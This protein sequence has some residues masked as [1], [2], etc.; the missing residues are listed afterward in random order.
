MLGTDAPRRS[1]EPR[2]TR[3][4]THGHAHASTWPRAHPHARTRVCTP[5]DRFPG[6]TPDKAAPEAAPAGGGRPAPAARPGA[7]AHPANPPERAGAGWGTAAPGPVP[8]RAPRD[9]RYLRRN[10]PPGP[11]PSCPVPSGPVP[12]GSARL[13]A[14]AAAAASM[15]GAV[16]A[17]AVPCPGPLPPAAARPGTPSSSGEARESRQ[18]RGEGGS[19]RTA[20]PP[21]SSLSPQPPVLGAPHRPIAPPVTKAS[22]RRCP[23]DEHPGSPRCTRAQQ[24]TQLGPVESGDPKPQRR[25]RGWG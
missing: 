7:A 24:D 23:R 5:R 25:S 4:H 18:P 15:R 1:R 8:P 3:V 10:V 9:R 19:R 17:G 13:G 6:R 21:V 14:A 12:L 11:V 22:P 16:A 20:C 2:H